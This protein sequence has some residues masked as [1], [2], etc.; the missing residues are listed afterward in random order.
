MDARLTAWAGAR[1]FFP[2]GIRGSCTE[3][4]MPHID[5]LTAHAE[6]LFRLGDSSL[7]ENVENDGSGSLLQAYLFLINNP[8]K[9]NSFTPDLNNALYF[10]YQ[11]Y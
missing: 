10:A 1:H 9:S 7:Y 2:I 6:F 8:V 3:Y 4:T 11:Y 5:L